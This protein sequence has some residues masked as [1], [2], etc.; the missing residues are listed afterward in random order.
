MN[1]LKEFGKGALKV[2]TI[3][4]KTTVKGV[5]L[6]AKGTKKTVIDNPKR[7]R[8]S[9]DI[10]TKA[11]EE[12]VA[13]ESAFM[14]SKGRFELK[15]KELYNKQKELINTHILR[16]EQL[17][18]YS[19]ELDEDNK[20]LNVIQNNHQ[21]YDF[22]DVNNTNL[23]DKST[24][25]I[26][27]PGILAGTVAS[28]ATVSLI[29]LLGTASTGTAIASL[30]GSA[31]VNAT[32]A[33]LG[34]GSIATGGGGIIGGIVTLGGIFVIPAIIASAFI[35]NN[36][37]E[38]NYNQAI[39]YKEKVE[40]TIARLKRAIINLETSCEIFQHYIFITEMLIKNVNLLNNLFES[41]ML[42]NKEYDTIRQLCIKAHDCANQLQNIKILNNNDE[43]NPSLMNELNVVYNKINILQFDIGFI[44]H[45]KK[46]SE[47]FND[48]VHI[49]KVKI[50]FD[51][52]I[53]EQFLKVFKEARYDI[54]IVSPW[55]SNWVIKD[56]FLSYLKSVLYRNVNIH[57]VCGYKRNTQ[58]KLFIST[59]E[60]AN[61]LR[62]KFQT[63]LLDINSHVNTHS[64]IIICD[65][66]YYIS[67]SFNFLSFQGK[68][69]PNTRQETVVYNEDKIILEKIKKH[70]FK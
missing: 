52:E 6:A 19:Q 7:N 39:D 51:S 23:F 15:S 4:A 64:K 67:G 40:Q 54:Y 70:Y 63:K 44:M 43:L 59:Q 49:S 62:Q 17:Y 53:R 21:N 27:F 24:N 46:Q 31:A 36:K 60:N 18:K 42:L 3:T 25:S 34:G 38:T 45:Y 50:Y 9:K 28:G 56:E 41:S 16:L 26:L 33:A 48:F 35:W 20:I 13:F 30:H 37:V 55:I 65:N 14:L 8:E 1:I 10:T 47:L 11:R 68:Y 61:I 66:K 5:Q 2:T 69:T 22:Y 57:I 32:L 29:S 58:D 12:Y